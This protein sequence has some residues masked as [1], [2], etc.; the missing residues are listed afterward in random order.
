[1]ENGE[2]TQRNHE[3]Y[4]TWVSSTKFRI[5]ELIILTMIHKE[6][7]CHNLTGFPDHD[8]PEDV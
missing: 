7:T 2:E 5:Q 4:T 3:V 6:W 8:S 1:M